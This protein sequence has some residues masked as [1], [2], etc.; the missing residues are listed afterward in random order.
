MR[1]FRTFRVTGFRTYLASPRLFYFQHICRLKVQDDSADELDGGAFGSAIHSVLEA[2]GERHVGT[3]PKLTAQEIERETFAA[4]HEFMGRQYGRHP[5][6]P[7]RAQI[8]SLE[9]R[10]RAFAEEQARLF[11]EGWEIAYV[12]KKGAA[13]EVPFAV[14]G[15]PD[16]VM[17]KG[18]IDRV[19]RHRDGRLRVM[20]YKTSS[21]PRQ[22]TIAHFSE[23]KG[24]WCDLQLP[25]YVKLLTQLGLTGKI[26][27]PGE[28]L[29]LVY[30]NLPPKRDDARIS[31]PFD[32]AL[33]PAAWERA[34]QIITEVCSGEG[35]R[36]VGNV[37]AYEDPVFHALCGTNGLPTTDEEED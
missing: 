5:L 7:V 33:V 18:R 21:T 2:F 16:D 17:L 27:E 28:Q 34:A 19:D 13:V 30:F 20:D 37:S 4:L 3:A 6:P 10:L 14:P 31:K 8:F 29:E 24:E 25:L 35:C 11:A 22:P 26:P 32:S 12:E 23:Q 15:A 9:E 36:E 1:A